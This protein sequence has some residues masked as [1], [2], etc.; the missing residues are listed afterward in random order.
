MI[1]FLL[2]SISSTRQR[3]CLYAAV[4]ELLRFCFSSFF[5]T[6]TLHHNYGSVV[7]PILWSIEKKSWSCFQPLQ[8]WLQFLHHQIQIWIGAL[9]SNNVLSWLSYICLDDRKCSRDWT[10][11]TQRPFRS[12]KSSLNALTSR[13]GWVSVHETIQFTSESFVTSLIIAKAWWQWWQQMWV[14]ACGNSSGWVSSC[15]SHSTYGIFFSKS[16]VV[17]RSENM[18][19]IIIL[20]I[21]YTDTT[22]RINMTTIDL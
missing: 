18:S 3:R 17:A 15:V 19:Q 20:E 6:S 22:T 12:W 11:V 7:Y 10:S 14:S 5:P 4:H 8:F 1:H 13:I 16:C 2:V 9:L 21:H